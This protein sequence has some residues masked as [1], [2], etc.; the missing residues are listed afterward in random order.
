M[1]WGDGVRSKRKRRWVGGVRSEREGRW[2]GGTEVGWLI[3]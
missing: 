3:W 1:R 2:G